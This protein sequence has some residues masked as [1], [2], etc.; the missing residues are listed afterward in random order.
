MCLHALASLDYS[1]L[2]E[3]PDDL[4]VVSGLF[5]PI[6]IHIHILILILGA[7]GILVLVRRFSLFRAFCDDLK[8]RDF[9]GT[10]R[11]TSDC[12]A[13]GVRVALNKFLPECLK[14]SRHA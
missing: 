12:R 3:R 8:H 1:N 5:N 14:P 2:F 11:D 7:G 6:L 13:C 10:V 9:V 4:A